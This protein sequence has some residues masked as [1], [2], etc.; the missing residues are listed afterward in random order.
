MKYT[1][2]WEPAA[3]SMLTDIWTNAPDRQAVTD[4]EAAISQLLAIVP[5]RYSF[6]LADGLYAIDYPPLRVLFELDV[7]R[8]IVRVV[9]VHAFP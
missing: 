4:A 5:L 8:G 6:P 9:G 1:V 2:I 7:A 3:L